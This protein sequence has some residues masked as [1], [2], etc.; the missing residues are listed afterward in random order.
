MPANTYDIVNCYESMKQS[1]YLWEPDWDDIVQL[2][3]PMCHDITT[4]RAPGQSR[5][6][7][8]YDSTAL[9]ANQ[10]LASNMM[11]GVT[12]NAIDWHRLQI[13]DESL[14]DD[15]ETQMWLSAANDHLLTVYGSSNFYQAMH[16]FYLNY[17]AFG[18][19][20]IFAGDGTSAPRGYLPNV[21]FTPVPHGTYVIAEDAD[22]DVDTLIRMI[23]YTPKQAI[24]LFGEDKVSGK[25]RELAK[26]PQMQDSRQAFLHAV[27]PR[28]EY[29]DGSM[30]NLEFP[31]ANCY[32]EMDQQHKVHE[33]GFLEF[34]FAVARWEKF[35][36]SPWG[37]GPGHMALPDTRTLNRMKELQIQM[38]ALWVQPPLKQVHES[39]IGAVSLEPLAIN[40][41]RDPNDLTPFELSGRPDLVQISQEDLRKSINDIF[42][43]DALQAIP[44]PEAGR[45]TAFEVA[46]RISQMQRLMGPAFHR[47]LSELL[48]PLIDRVF[49]LEWR[50][51]QIPMPP[52]QVLEAAMRRGG[53]IDVEYLGPLARA[54]KSVDVQSIAQIY[55]IGAQIMEATQN[56]A[57]FDVLDSDLAVRKAAE[58]ANVP[59]EI[60]RDALAVARIRQARQ[61]AQ[62]QRAQM[63]QQA[64]Q[65]QTLR[66]VAP[67]IKTLQEGQGGRMAA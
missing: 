63:E 33:S 22:G 52:V 55:G 7:E 56:P 45:M 1:R 38:L 47:L 19:A 64:A 31:F 6:L 62:E 48:N 41:V 46:Q 23:H 66:D 37:F 54:Q 39:V 3:A 5:T 2:M 36:D 51:G 8:I 32:I 57:V 42:F 58:A 9:M 16:T 20:A 13:R 10:T 53:Q 43:V 50:K 34:P 60:V 15:Q 17:G 67:F 61:V 28:E 65:A 4:Q 44:P 18:T 14:Q 27:Y 21:H 24:T 35:S 29:R 12:N 30:N 49:G 40:V 59:P 26:N 25:I 11:G